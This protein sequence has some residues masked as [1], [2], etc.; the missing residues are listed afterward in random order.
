MSEF[1]IITAA[2]VVPIAISLIIALFIADRMA[3]SMY[4][5][6]DET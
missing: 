4:G 5:D 6:D 3:N 2:V 1:L